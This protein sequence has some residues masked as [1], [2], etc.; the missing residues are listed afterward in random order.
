MFPTEKDFTIGDPQINDGIKTQYKTINKKTMEKKVFSVKDGTLRINNNE[1]RIYS[2]MDDKEGRM[3]IGSTNKDYCTNNHHIYLLPST[4]IRKPKTDEELAE[5]EYPLNE[6]FKDETKK[7][8]KHYRE[9]F[10]AGRKSVGGE[11]HLTENDIEKIIFLAR[12]YED[13][14]DNYSYDSDYIIS[15]LTPP[16]YPTEITVDYDGENY[17]WET[18]KPSYE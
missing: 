1:L 5:E 10:L 17:L 3:C 12:R 8:I 18:L 7:I 4:L 16:I 15:S 2:N 11:F 6:T 14:V 13:K 9:G